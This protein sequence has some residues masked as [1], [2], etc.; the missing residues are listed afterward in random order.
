[1]LKMGKHYKIGRTNSVGR[2]ERE[3]AMQMPERAKTVHTITTDDP[4]GIEAYWH[5]RF[6][7]K[8]TQGEWFL[9][10]ASDVRIFRRRK[11]M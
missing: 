2:R 5:R 4:V 11:F 3:L 8:R 7:D 10:D 6:E 9:L 1:M